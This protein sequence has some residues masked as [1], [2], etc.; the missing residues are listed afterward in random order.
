[1]RKAY[2]TVQGDI[3]TTLASYNGGIQGASQ[4]EAAWSDQMHRYVKWGMGIYQDAL[5]GKQESETL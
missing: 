4:P 1:L 3:R 2:Q 5:A